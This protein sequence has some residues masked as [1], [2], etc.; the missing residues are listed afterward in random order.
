LELQAID[1]PTGTEIF[2]NEKFKSPPF[3]EDRLYSVRHRIAPAS[4]VSKDEY[5]ELDFPGAKQD[6][7]LFL[8]GWV[9]WPDGSTFLAR[10]QQRPFRFPQLEMQDERGQWQVVNPDMGMPAGK[11]KTIAVDLHFISAARKVRVAADLPVHWQEAFLAENTEASNVIRTR[12]PAAAADLHYRGFS[13][14][15]IDPRRQQPDT[16]AYKLATSTPFWNPT[17]GYYTRFGDVLSLAREIDDR[18][19]VM[20]SGDELTLRFTDTLPPLKPGWTRD[21][22]LKVDGWAKDRDANTAHGGTVEPLPF[23]AMSVYPYP[24]NEHFP[25][26]E[27]HAVYRGEYNTRPALRPLRSLTE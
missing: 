7:T 5:L 14:S 16:Y 1:H 27:A 4:Q 23:H 2:T 10:S 20:G 22:L 11:P 8:K 24:T 18:L 17:P 12:I 19:I 3:P 9:D 13:E 26:D 21:F 15:T 25:D 6:A